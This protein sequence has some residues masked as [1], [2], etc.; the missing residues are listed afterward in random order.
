MSN[1]PEVDATIARNKA[2]ERQ[3]KA[4]IARDQREWEASYRR[5]EADDNAARAYKA[6]LDQAGREEAKRRRR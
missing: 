5:M 4:G 3:Q 6:E 1:T 2:R